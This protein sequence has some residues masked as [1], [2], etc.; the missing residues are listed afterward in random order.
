MHHCG[1]RCVVLAGIFTVMHESEAGTKA[2]LER[3]PAQAALPAATED[4][5][6][7]PELSQCAGEPRPTK[8]VGRLN[9]PSNQD[10]GSSDT[11]HAQQKHTR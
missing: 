10:V 8:K 11:T 9:G 5:Q 2:E 3:V 1:A 4:M 7:L 6:P